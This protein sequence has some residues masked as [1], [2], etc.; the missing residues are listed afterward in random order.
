MFPGSWR[1]ELTRLRVEMEKLRYQ[2]RG[3]YEPVNPSPFQSSKKGKVSNFNTH[4]CFLSIS[5]NVCTEFL[6]T[7]RKSS[8]CLQIRGWTASNDGGEFA[9]LVNRSK[10][11]KIQIQSFN[12]NIQIDPVFSLSP[13]GSVFSCFR[14]FIGINRLLRF[15]QLK[16]PTIQNHEKVGNMVFWG[17]GLRCSQGRLVV[18]ELVHGITRKYPH[19]SS[20]LQILTTT[21]RS[22][23]KSAKRSCK[24]YRFYRFETHAWHLHSFA[25]AV[26]GIYVLI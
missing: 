18:D 2:R 14:K 19:I 24:F 13:E 16:K 7:C 23:K 21:T 3:G 17:L 11:N 15:H 9:C 8:K 25:G 22:P 12:Q 1:K 6:N 10:R 5:I 26:G 20:Y 4:V